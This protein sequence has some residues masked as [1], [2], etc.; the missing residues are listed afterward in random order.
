MYR[1]IKE[2]FENLKKVYLKNVAPVLL[3][4]SDC[5][6]SMPGLYQPNKPLVRIQGFQ[7][8]LAVLQSK[9]RPRKLII[10]GSDGKEY[11]FLLKGREDLRLDE[12]V[13]QLLA[14][15]NKL[16]GLNQSTLK[17]DLFVTRYSIIPLSVNTGL[18]GWVEECDTLNELIKEYRTDHRIRPDV[19]KTLYEKCCDEYTQ[20]PMINKV[21]IF[22]HVLESTQGLD[23]AKVLW[24]K[25]ANSEAW[26]E[27]RTCYT[28]SLATM[29]MV[30]Y[31]LGLGDRHPS[32][33]MIQRKTGRIVHIDFGDC[34]E[35][36]MLRDKFPERVPFRL[37]RMLQKA[38]EVCGIEGNYKSTC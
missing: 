8:E 36:A 9:Q 35:V 18:I 15:V 16:L 21:E 5:K 12:R 23:L 20:L 10:Y 32:N 30:G 7:N 6:L 4:I 11:T 29:S 17:K 24:L 28:R 33:I 2:S 26:I 19:E 1:R 13:M 31:I 25:S 34:F 3:S 37:T 14:L 27:R 38:M 22:R